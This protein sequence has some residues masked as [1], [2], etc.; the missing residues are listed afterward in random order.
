M[1]RYLILLSG[2]LFL[3]L[4]CEKN[5]QDTTFSGEEKVFFAPNNDSDS[6]L[7][8]FANNVAADF[9]DLQLPLNIMGPIADRDRTVTVVV[10]PSET[11]ALP[12]EYE[13]GQAVVPA[14]AATGYVPLRIINA[15]RL[16]EQQVLLTLRLQT[17]PDFLVD[18][19][20]TGELRELTRFRV[21]WTNILN[22]PSDWPA[23]WGGYSRVKHRLVIDL[24]GHF[25][26]SGTEWNAGNYLYVIMGICSQWLAEYNADHGEPYRDE[27]GNPIRFCPGC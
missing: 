25:I 27:N 10:D 9:R 8:S 26:Y 1:Y 4:S 6:L 7:H 5:G 18:V 20:R 16:E 12:E 17:S 14:G 21:L 23:L 22:R 15:T 24:T 2:C 19:E 3:A 11:T 13:L